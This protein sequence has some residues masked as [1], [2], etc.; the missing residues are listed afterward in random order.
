MSH[1]NP[2]FTFISPD[3]LRLPNEYRNFLTKNNIPYT[4][5]ND[6]THDIDQANIIYMTRVQKE[7]FSDPMDYERVKDVYRLTLPMLEN[8]KGTMKILHPLPRV[9]EIDTRVDNSPHAYYFKQA[10]NGVYTRMAII[11]SLMNLK[12]K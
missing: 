5:S 12:S 2:S 11:S 6:L 8:C 10:E 1:F 9:N 7:R 4:E 3:E